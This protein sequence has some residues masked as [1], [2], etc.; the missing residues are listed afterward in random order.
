MNKCRKNIIGLKILK[1]KITKKRKA[2]KENGR[3][4][5]KGKLHRTAEA[6]YRC[7]SL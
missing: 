6:Q 7:S 3:I 2:K 1:V 4:K 5:K